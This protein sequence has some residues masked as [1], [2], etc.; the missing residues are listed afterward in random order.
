MFSKIKKAYQLFKSID[1]EQLDKLSRKID[2]PKAMESFSQLDDKQLKGLMKMLEGG[3]PK[4][5]LPPINSDFYELHLRLDDEDR[6]LQLRVR[7][8]MEREIR[9]LVNH[10]WLR[11]EFPFEIIPKLAELD[12]CG[13][14]YKGYGCAGRSSLMEGIIAME[15]ARIDASVATF[16]GVQSG[17]AMGSIYLCGSDE[18]K[19]EW[20]PAMQQMKL[21]GAF[22]LTEPEVGSGAAGG[23]TVTA[24]KT[25]KGWVLNGQ[26]KWIGNA[27][28]ADV[29]I[30]W[31][32]DVGDGEVKGFLVRKGTPGFEVEKIKGK[33]ALRIVQN[34]LITLTDCIVPESD[35]LQHANS[36]KDTAKVLQLT[37]A[38]VAWMAVGCACGAY[39]N[40]LDYTRKR[41]QFGKPI[42]SF[43]L[44]QNHLVE[45]LSNLTAMQALVYRLSELQDTGMLRDE[46]ASLAKVFCTLRTRDIVS[47]A[48]EV[49]GGNGILLEYDVARFLADAEAIYS[50]EGTKE[51]NSLI[52]GR[53]ITGFSA[54]V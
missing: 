13:L 38:G 36:F 3:E 30:I 40:A 31:A 44:I 21:I 28:F 26:K 45:M 53:S 18:Q 35:R 32:K 52:V 24:H 39:E 25:D 43:Q 33:M 17:L 16:F 8:F 48:R 37:R 29:T 1:F 5:E 12:I 41:K 22:G 15:I 6:A 4:K 54:F 49:M 7:E 10:Y 2:L 11:D 19:Q 34:G 47:Q 14:T 42:A 9:P 23:L 27:P 46:H 50:Y 20:L 51:I